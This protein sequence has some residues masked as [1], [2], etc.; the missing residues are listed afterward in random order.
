MARTSKHQR[1]P[2]LEQLAANLLIRAGCVSVAE[3]IEVRWSARMRSTAG[4][5]Y[6]HKRLILLN[7]L[8]AGLGQNEVDRTLRHELAHFVAQYR[9]GR[10]R[11][12]PHGSEWREACRDMGIPGEPRCHTLPFRSA[13]LS[14]KYF[15]RCKSCGTT[16]ARVRPPKR[17]LACI[18]CCRVYSGG[19]YDERFRFIPVSPP[20]TRA[21]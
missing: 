14:R 12:A 13:R 5:A 20:D 11:I 8:L 1:D 19:K 9:A 21:A 10:R 6:F 16:L 4:I 18:K 3:K 17:P 7:P 2:I 15:Y